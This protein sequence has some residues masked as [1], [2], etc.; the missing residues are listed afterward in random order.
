MRRYLATVTPGI[1][2]GYWNA[3]NRPACARSSGA[4]SVMSAPWK[5]ISPSV[6]SSAGWPMIA[7]A[8]VDLPEPLGPI[9]AWICPL[10]TSRSRPLRISLS[11]A[12]TCRLRIS[13]SAIRLLGRCVGVRAAPGLRGLPGEGLG[14]GVLLREGDQLGPGGAGERL[15]D[16]ALHPGP[17]K[18]RRAGAVAVD[19]VRT[20]HP[21]L[22]LD[23]KALHRRDRSLERLDDVDH[24]DLRRRLRQAV[25]AVGTAHRGHELG[26]A[27]LRHQVLEVG[28]RQRLRLGDG[29]EGDGLGLVRGRIAGPA[30]ELHHQAH[31]VLG[32]GR[33]QHL[34]QILAERSVIQ[35]PDAPAGAG[36]PA[37]C[38]RVSG[39]TNR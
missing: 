25:A 12:V 16:A 6:I 37:P 23:V 32:F 20:E 26:L 24:R 33:K 35:R 17:Q 14:G 39:C 38:N 29:A 15:R 4:A 7:L 2:T 27:Q 13:R 34:A 18:L 5:T 36:V 28:Q 11:S 9:R 21:S 19:L 8:S 3:M 1:A 31:P 10:E 22:A 30:T